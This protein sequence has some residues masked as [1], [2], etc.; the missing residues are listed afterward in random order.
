MKSRLELFSIQ[1]GAL[2]GRAGK[3]GTASMVGA[4]KSAP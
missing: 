2:D 3:A 4:A 1:A